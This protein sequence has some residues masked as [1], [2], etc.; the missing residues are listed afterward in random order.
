[1]V[2]RVFFQLGLEFWL[3]PF[4]TNKKNGLRLGS[5]LKTIVMIN[6]LAEAG[7]K[8][9]FCPCQLSMMKMIGRAKVGRTV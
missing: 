5:K 4:L 1:M 6:P 3:S 9:T 2:N 8:V 7:L